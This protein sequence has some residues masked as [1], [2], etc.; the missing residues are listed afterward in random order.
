M[1]QIIAVANRKGGVGKTTTAVN[2]GAALA[3]MGKR[4]LLADLDPSGDL[5]NH[6]GAVLQDGDLTAYE[7]IA[8]GANIRQAIRHVQGERTGTAYDVIPADG[9]LENIA[10]D[11]PQTRLRDALA[12]VGADYDYIIL[13]AQPTLGA[14]TAQVLT[15]ADS[16]LIPTGANYLALDAVTATAQ[17]IESARETLNPGIEILGVLLTQYNPRIRHQQAIRDAIAEILP[18]AVC[19]VYTSTGTGVAEAAANGTDLYEYISG[20][21]NRRNTRA[22]QQYRELAEMIANGEAE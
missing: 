2:L 19:E 3:G 8:D 20:H 4:V 21:R 17:V 5:T 13:D 15:A 10:D 12:T 9:A 1:A 11:V 7:I 14:P 22:A 18:D 16:V 6:V